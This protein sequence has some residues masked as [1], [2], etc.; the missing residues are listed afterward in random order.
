[1]QHA[2]RTSASRQTTA[3][4]ATL[5]K[6]KNQNVHKQTKTNNATRGYTSTYTTSAGYKGATSKKENDVICVKME[7]YTSRGH[8]SS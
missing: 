4:T 6:V 8:M 2:K 3:R 7:K 5:E 1:M